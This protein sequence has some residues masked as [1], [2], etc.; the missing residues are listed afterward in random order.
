M[1]NLKQMFYLRR[2]KKREKYAGR[3][4]MVTSNEKRLVSG[5]FYS[6]HSSYMS[7]SPSILASD[8][9]FYPLNLIQLG[10]F[11]RINNSEAHKSESSMEVLIQAGLLREG[12]AVDLVNIQ[13]SGTSSVLYTYKVTNLDKETLLITDQDKMGPARFHYIRMVLPLAATIPIY[14]ADNMTHTSFESIDDSWYY[15]L[16]S[17]ESITRQV[18]QYGFKIFPKGNVTGW[19][20]FP[21]QINK[22]AYWHQQDGRIWAGSF[23]V[24][25]SLLF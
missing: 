14:F 24:Q 10:G 8:F 9:L 11:Y 18:L 13:K 23:T 22:N 17:G 15:P 2:K 3:Y 16:N 1:I 19:F 20:I 4:F 6:M 25:N 7:P 5:Y 12:I 21:G